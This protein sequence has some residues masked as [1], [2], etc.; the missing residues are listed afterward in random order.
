V[1][2]PASALRV[3]AEFPPQLAILDIGLPVMSGY[4][5][6]AALGALPGLEPCRYLALTGF[7]EPCDAQRIIA[8]GFDHHLSKPLVFSELKALL[9]SALTRPR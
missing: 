5:L 7:V 8:A 1:H 3:S 4:E 6:L 9:D 2:Y